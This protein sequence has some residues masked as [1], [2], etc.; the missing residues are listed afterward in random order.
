LYLILLFHNFLCSTSEK[1]FDCRPDTSKHIEYLVNLMAVL[2]QYVKKYNNNSDLV[3]PV[4]KV[5]IFIYEDSNKYI[6]RYTLYICMDSYIF[7][8]IYTYM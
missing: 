2:S 6:Y 8:Y 4:P 7:S 3:G 5:Y 1:E